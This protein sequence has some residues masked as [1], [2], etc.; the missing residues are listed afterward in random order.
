MRPITIC[1]TAALL[2]TL[3]A[4]PAHAFGRRFQCQLA[5]IVEQAF[6]QSPLGQLSQAVDS[7]NQRLDAS[8]RAPVRT[9]V[10][11]PC[12]QPVAPR[13]F[14][15]AQREV[16]FPRFRNLLRRRLISE[17]KKLSAPAPTD[18]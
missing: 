7:L 1:L 10:S 16:R 15:P 18:K 3:F 17:M 4:S 13:Q 9:D 5:D 2:A 12:Q 6:E 14:T 8:R 11:R